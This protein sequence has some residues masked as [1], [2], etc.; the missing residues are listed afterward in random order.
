MQ[1]HWIISLYQISLI[2]IEKSPFSPLRS[3]KARSTSHREFQ[4][5]KDEN[6]E[7]RTKKQ[8][9]H[10]SS[11]NNSAS[12]TPV[13]G[14]STVAYMIV[15][16]LSQ[17]SHWLHQLPTV[18]QASE[19]TNLCT[20]FLLQFLEQWEELAMLLASNKQQHKEITKSRK[21]QQPT[22]NAQNRTAEKKDQVGLQ[23]DFIQNHLEYSKCWNSKKEIFL[24]EQ[25]SSPL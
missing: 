2:R 12:L 8:K 19:N 16:S 3:C 18:V 13:Q 20:K 24:I 6:R 4:R 7:Q 15:T 14:L 11:M 5:S 25:P 22:P 9:Q 1:G 10:E 23:E 21:T 17:L